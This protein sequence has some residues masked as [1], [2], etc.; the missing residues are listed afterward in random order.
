MNMSR[1]EYNTGEIMLTMEKIN[2]Q[3]YTKWGAV[4]PINNLAHG[5]KG[6]YLKK[7]NL[8]KKEIEDIF[9]DSKSGQ[10]ANNM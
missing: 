8:S 1:F 3:L 5:E 7:Q 9:E 2:G 4:A 10:H 6:I